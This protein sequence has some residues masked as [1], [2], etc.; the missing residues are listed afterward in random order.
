MRKKE[1]EE[2]KVLLMMVDKQFWPQSGQKMGSSWGKVGEDSA[3]F[4][5]WRSGPFSN[6]TPILLMGKLRSRESKAGPKDKQ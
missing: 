5:K 6:K 1:S 4:L 3:C 2:E